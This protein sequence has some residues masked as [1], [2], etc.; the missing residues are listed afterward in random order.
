MVRGDQ[1][2]SID[3]KG[4]FIGGSVAKILGGVET[5][6]LVRRV[7]KSSLVKRGLTIYI[8]IV[9]IFSHAYTNVILVTMD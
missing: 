4:K 1:Y 6:P 2:I 7:I 3:F 5:P 9:L 8:I